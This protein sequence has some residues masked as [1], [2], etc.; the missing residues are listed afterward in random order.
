MRDSTDHLP[1]LEKCDIIY[2]RPNRPPGRL[3]L[4]RPSGEYRRVPAPLAELPMLPKADRQG[5][6]CVGSHGSVVSRKLPSKAVVPALKSLGERF[7]VDAS[8]RQ[9]NDPNT[10]IWPLLKGLLYLLNPVSPFLAVVEDR[11]RQPRFLPLTL[12][13]HRDDRSAA[14]RVEPPLLS[15]LITSHVVMNWV[16]DHTSFQV[17]QRSQKPNQSS[18][19]FDARFNLTM[20]VSP[21]I[22]SNAGPICLEGRSPRN[23]CLSLMGDVEVA[24]RW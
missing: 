24:N 1:F 9:I 19:V 16:E 13:P 21:Q 5:H 23:R 8:M 20:F 14:L 15:H 6:Q 12:V 22:T 17:S 7:S 2:P 10:N 3:P 18:N 4:P 11:P